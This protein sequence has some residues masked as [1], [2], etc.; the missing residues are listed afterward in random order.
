MR[1]KQEIFDIVTKHMLMQNE[2]AEVDYQCMYKTEN[3]LKC[4]IGVLFTAPNHKY[5]PSI[6]EVTALCN[7]HYEDLKSDLG[8]PD[9]S[10][11]TSEYQEHLA[12]LQD[13]QL[14]H[15]ECPVDRWG[16]ELQELADTYSLI[17]NGKQYETQKD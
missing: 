11:D 17:Y 10:D 2:K 9:N 14:I 8:L 4:A 5:Y 12:F 16:E 13:L 3:G 7:Q 15:D 6:M 1:T